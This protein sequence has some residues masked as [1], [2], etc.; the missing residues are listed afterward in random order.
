MEVNLSKPFPVKVRGDLLSVLQDIAD[1]DKRRP[2]DEAEWLLEK[3]LEE[4]RDKQTAARA[5]ASD[6]PQ[7]WESPYA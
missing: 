6:V 7:H 2:R 3:A 1:R 5:P 4:I